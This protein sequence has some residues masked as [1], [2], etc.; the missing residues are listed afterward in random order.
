MVLTLFAA[1][2]VFGCIGDG[3]TAATPTA[4]P[5]VEAGEPSEQPSA[6]P[7]EPAE[8]GLFEGLDY[9]GLLA[10]GQSGECTVVV[11]GAEYSGTTQLWFANG[12]ARTETETT[13]GGETFTLTAIYKDGKTYSTLPDS[14]KVDFFADC[15]WLEF[16]P[17]ATQ[18]YSDSGVETYSAPDME[19]VPETSF[20]CRAATV[21]ASKFD[22][23]GKV[24][25]MQE[26]IDEMLGDLEL[27]EG[28]E[29]PGYT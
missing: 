12:K 23:P 18:D 1:L 15:D 16:S 21:P 26:M 25:N 17:E 9:A 8:G 27:P 24:C 2:L 29:I 28:M 7:S 19:N 14:A 4:S 13:Q 5:S 6:A 22:T 10:S 11:T 3:T 20:E